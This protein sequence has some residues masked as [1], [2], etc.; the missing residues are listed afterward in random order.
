MFQKSFVLFSLLSLSFAQYNY[1]AENLEFAQDEDPLYEHL[2]I[3]RPIR[4]RRQT[5]YGGLTPANPGAKATIGA[6]GNIFNNNG[7]SV[8]ANGEISKTFKP[9][10]P[11]SIG[12]GVNYQGPRAGVSGNVN[13]VHR[14]GTD[15]G[16]SGNTNIWR[17]PNGRTSVDA[18]AGYNRHFG[19]P[20]GTGR[21]N[22]NGNINFNHRF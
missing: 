4:V 15:V 13:H 10:G 16:V 12:G 22:Y 18:N 17:S 2:T 7:H 9:I 5:V 3:I 20:G 8:H 14:F 11:T 21:P 6:Q 1:E 19:G